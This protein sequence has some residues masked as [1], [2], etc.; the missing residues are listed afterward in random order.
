MN[1]TCRKLFKN[2]KDY[3][4]LENDI[5]IINLSGWATDMIQNVHTDMNYCLTSELMRE[6]SEKEDISELMDEITKQRLEN[7]T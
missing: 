6:L 1:Q 2:E 7:I 4:V 3:I 5:N